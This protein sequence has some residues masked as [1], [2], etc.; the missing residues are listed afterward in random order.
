[1][2]DLAINL[3]YDDPVYDE[4][5]VLIDPSLPIKNDLTLTDYDLALV[6]DLDGLRQKLMIKLQFFYGEWYLDTTKGIK[7]YTDILIPN[8]EL[9]KVQ[10]ILKAA[11]TDTEGVNSLLSFDAKFDPSG[12]SLSV[13]FKADTVYGNLTIGTTLP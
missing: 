4:A 13:K 3:E 5:G 11:I 7:Y 10:A 8:P 2:K 1:M 9:N 12:R 6:D